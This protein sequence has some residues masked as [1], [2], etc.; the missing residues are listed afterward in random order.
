MQSEWELPA[1]HGPGDLVA[2]SGEGTAF[3]AVDLLRHAAIVAEQLPAMPAGAEVLVLCRDP[4]ALAVSA[5]AAWRTGTLVALP[6]NLGRETIADLVRGDRIRTILHDG[7]WETGIDVSAVVGATLSSVAPF[8]GRVL[9]RGDQPLATLYTSGSTGDRR[10][11]VKLACQL[12]AEARL[13]GEMLGINPSDRILA[14]VPSQH[15]Y[16][17]LVGVLTPLM[18][19]A[20][21]VCGSPLLAEEVAARAHETGASVLA[22]VPAHL[23]ALSTLAPGDLAGV[24]LI[25]S[26]S[27]PLDPGTAA[28]LARFRAQLVE[29][30]GSTETGGIAL[31]R[32]PDDR[33]RPLPG[34]TVTA[35]ADGGMLL[36]SPFL[37]PR[38]PRPYAG[39]DRIALGDDGSFRHLGRADGVLKIAGRRIAP[40]EIEARLRTIAGVVDASVTAVAAGGGR[41][42]E[43]WAIAVAPSLDADTIRRRLLDWFDPVMLP[44]RLRLVSEIPREA[45]GKITLQGWRDLFGEAKHRRDFEVASRLL[46]GPFRGL[47]GPR[48]R[49]DPQRHRVDG[50][51]ACL[52]RADPPATALARQIPPAGPTRGHADFTAHA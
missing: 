45:T 26:S 37:D 25:V 15:I 38:G 18:H 52:A 43:I 23:R 29:L 35:A 47:P 41:G 46:C 5:L 1:R 44:R 9:L 33:W 30:F 10:R 3:T 24:R 6:P 32:P 19:G 17:L 50:E 7:N 22:S 27:A 49:G 36:D 42:H 48:R 21:I 2:W 20:A 28:Q 14:S 51:H 34:I 16:G 39:A 13:L 4:Y 12:L 11:S 40:D 8:P 31:R